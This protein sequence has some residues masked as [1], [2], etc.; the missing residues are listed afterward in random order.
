MQVQGVEEFIEQQATTMAIA[1]GQ[2]LMAK[3]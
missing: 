2:F 3:R 1:Q